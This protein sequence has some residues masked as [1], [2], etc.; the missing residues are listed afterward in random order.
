MHPVPKMP[1]NC[2]PQM[3]DETHPKKYE[4]I[5]A[6]DFLHERLVALGLL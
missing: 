3:I 5:E 4:D 6:G 1:L 2:L